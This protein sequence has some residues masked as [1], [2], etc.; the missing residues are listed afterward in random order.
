MVPDE[1]IKL[2]C[3]LHDLSM[4]CN[5]FAD[6]EESRGDPSAGEKLGEFKGPWTRDSRLLGLA[7]SIIER[8]TYRLPR[9]IVP[10]YFPTSEH[11]IRSFSAYLQLSVLMLN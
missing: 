2:G 9:Q 10:M 8:Q 3:G 6:D 11:R 7:W 5:S 4:L 1:L